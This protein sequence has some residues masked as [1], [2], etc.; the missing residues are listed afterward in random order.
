MAGSPGGRDPT[1][2]GEVRG[3][4]GRELAHREELPRGVGDGQRGH[5]AAG[6]H[7]F[8]ELLQRVGGVQREGSH[9]GAPQRREVSAHAEVLPE[10]AGEGAD[11]GSGGARHGRVHVDGPGR[12]GAVAR[13]GLRAANRVHLE[14]GHRDR[15]G[16]Q[17]HILSAAHPRVG[18]LTVHLDRAHRGGDLLDLAREPRH[19]GQNLLVRDPGQQLGVRRARDVALGVVGHGGRPQTDAGAV[20]LVRAGDPGEQLGG[21]L[22]TDHQHARRRRVQCPGVTHLPGPR[23]PAHAR[24]DVVRGP[25]QRLVHDHEPRD[26]GKGRGRGGNVLSCAHGA[27]A[28]GVQRGPSASSSSDGVR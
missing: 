15:A 8:R 26:P 27:Q 18:A 3:L 16:R 1:A 20:G 2:V 17:L 5:R 4:R 7:L 23:Q 9:A 28:C 22:H 13:C 24:D 6:A 10:V 12:P 19:G 11:V 14:P 25:A 21:L